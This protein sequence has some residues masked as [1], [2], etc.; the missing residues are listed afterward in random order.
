M[1]V[2]ALVVCAPGLEPVLD[3][4]LAGLGIRRRRLAKGGVSVRVTTRELYAIN[5]WARTASR[6]LV[7]MGRFRATTFRDL[8]REIAALDWTPWLPEDS[9]VKLRVSS[10]SSRLRSK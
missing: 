8:E 10:G 6:V 3:G 1:T 4:E 7:R 9:R 2:D 5:V